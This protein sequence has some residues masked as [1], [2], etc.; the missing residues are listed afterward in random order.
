[1]FPPLL[2]SPTSQRLHSPFSLK[3]GILVIMQHPGEP[4]WI[5][6]ARCLEYNTGVREGVFPDLLAPLRAIPGASLRCPPNTSA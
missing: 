4:T 3:I 5:L 1:M 2:H 6:L